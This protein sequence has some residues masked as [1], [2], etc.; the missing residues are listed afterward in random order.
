MLNGNPAKDDWKEPTDEE[1]AEY[2]RK[3]LKGE[4]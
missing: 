2:C 1:S 3:V 4:I